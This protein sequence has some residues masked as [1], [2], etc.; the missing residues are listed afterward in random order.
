M[1]NTFDIESDSVF[2][3]LY[4]FSLC[5]GLALCSLSSVIQSKRKA[6]ERERNLY[7]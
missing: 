4:V 5:C 3:L 7:F 1:G 2:V 6:V